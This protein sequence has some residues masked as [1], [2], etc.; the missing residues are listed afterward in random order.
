MLNNVRNLA[1]KHSDSME[2]FHFVQHDNEQYNDI[3]MSAT[4]IALKID[5]SHQ[6]VGAI[7]MSNPTLADTLTLTCTWGRAPLP[8]SAGPQAAY[9][10]VE[11]LAAATAEAGPVN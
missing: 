1:A 7:T 4:A 6:A 2:M 11:T 8:A 10:L 3:P 9:L 5:N